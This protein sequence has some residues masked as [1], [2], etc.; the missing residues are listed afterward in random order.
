ME[1]NSLPLLL[2]NRP[3]SPPKSTGLRK[4]VGKAVIGAS[5][6]EGNPVDEMAIGASSSQGLIR[7]RSLVKGYLGRLMIKSQMRLSRKSSGPPS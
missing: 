3:A 7:T 5:S 6:N 1:S 2:A 4:P